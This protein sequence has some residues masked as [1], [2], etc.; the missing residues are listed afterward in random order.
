MS[1]TPPPD[2]NKV[3]L[4]LAI[5]ASAGILVYTLRS[6]H[7]THVGDNTHHLPHGGR[8][9]DGN[10]RI[11]YNGPQTGSSHVFSVLPFFAAI[12]LTLVIHFLSCSRRRV[13]IRCSESH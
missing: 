4:T 7:L 3:Y 9:C 2:Y 12:T 1:F 5:G 13:C 6:N 11:L 10:K 8:Y